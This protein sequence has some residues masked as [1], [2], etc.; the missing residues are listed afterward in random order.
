MKRTGLLTS[1]IV[2]LLAIAACSGKSSSKVESST[3]DTT[4]SAVS[5]D[6]D[7]AY[8][9]VAEQVAFGPRVPGSEGHSRCVD[10]LAMRLKNA[11]AEVS[12]TDTVVTDVENR[13]M[14]VRNITGV[15]NPNGKRR[16][17]LVAHYDTRPWADKDANRANHNRAIDGANDGASGVA[18]LL[19]IA[20][21]IDQ[22]PDNLSVEMLF[23]DAE[24]SGLYDG[25]DASWC[26]GSQLWAA[27]RKPTDAKIDYGILLDMVGGRD[28]QFNREYFSELY[29]QAVNQ[30]IWQAAKRAGYGS[31]FPDEIGGA[32]NDD[33][34]YLMQAGFPVADIIECNSA[35]TE[36]FN[37]TWHTMDDNLDNIDRTTLKIVGEVVINTLQGR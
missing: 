9:F 27:M 32:V 24:D 2:V 13:R 20:R 5:F 29:A 18:V 22:L 19:E 10:Y 36:S 35:E 26:V 17:L 34:V 12:V 23:V 11:G 8:K 28:A 31:R 37:P 21:Q 16:V 4:R 33:H 25:D 6:A 7:S 3:K 14:P 30:R 15:F 1:I